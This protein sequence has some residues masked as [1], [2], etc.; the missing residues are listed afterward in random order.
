MSIRGFTDRLLGEQAKEI[1]QAKPR[2]ITITPGSLYILSALV[3]RR[4]TEPARWILFDS[5]IDIL[6]GKLTNLHPEKQDLLAS[7]LGELIGIMLFCQELG[8]DIELIRLLEITEGKM[9]D[10]VLI[11]TT[12]TA[13]MA[14]I[15]ECK[16]RVEDV[17]NINSRS[18]VY[19]LCQ[20][21]REFRKKGKDQVETIQ[22]AQARA[23]SRIKIKQQIPL[24]ISSMAV[25]K[26]VLVSAIPDARIIGSCR[27]SV[28]FA[29]RIECSPKVTCETCMKSQV[30][31]S[32]ANVISVLHQEKV[33]KGGVLDKNL[34][35]FLAHYRS[36]Q[37][38]IWSGNDQIFGAFLNAFIQRIPN[39][40]LENMASTLVFMAVTL[41]EAAVSQR[42][43]HAEIETESLRKI[44]PED[45]QD[46]L[47]DVLEDFKLAQFRS[48][49]VKQEVVLRTEMP[50][51]RDATQF[52]DTIRPKNLSLSNKE[53]S[54]PRTN[55][56]P[57]EAQV[58]R[59][60]L[61]SSRKSEEI[62]FET[63]TEFVK[64][65]K[66]TGKLLIGTQL[67]DDYI[68]GS[69][70]REDR[71]TI[72][73]RILSTQMDY[74][75]LKEYVELCI[76][77]LRPSYARS[78][79]WRREYFQADGKEEFFLG[80]SWDEF[81]YPNPNNDALLGITVWLARDGR[82]TIIVRKRNE[83]NSLK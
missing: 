43:T 23:G 67:K 36:V 82:A 60:M 27:N 47:N 32:P 11:Q 2:Y 35:Q 21:I 77:Q 73:I 1:Q 45:L 25:T 7:T 19:D 17:H 37:R 79:T 10:F 24:G 51:P 64:E 29:K 18:G 8:G 39:S 70:Q 6:N 69:V 5:L 46:I 66:E 75:I 44:T 72:A 15:L 68:F 55:N 42:L 30:A 26:N 12:G 14:H 3:G 71:F 31:S 22:L 16:G 49:R 52:A 48:Q 57:R 56:E 83:E 41:I 20:E 33:A 59:Y 63:L 13:E 76:R 38:A 58:E 40:P 54:G 34:T 9:P 74:A 53:D 62:N 61:L 80:E 4:M 65:D 81:P 28:Q 78:V 50:D